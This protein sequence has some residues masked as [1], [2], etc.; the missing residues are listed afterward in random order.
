[1]EFTFY[2]DN[3]RADVGLDVKCAASNHCSF[4]SKAASFDH[5][6]NGSCAEIVTN[7]SSSGG[8]AEPGERKK[9]L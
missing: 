6:E 4:G 9:L 5:V 1:M 2:G 3:T 8:T 7:I